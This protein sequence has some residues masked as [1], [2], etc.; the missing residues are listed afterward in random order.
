MRGR[1]AS[2]LR[3]I[4]RPCRHGTTWWPPTGQAHR[5]PTAEL[6][7]A[8]SCPIPSE[9]VAAERLLVHELDAAHEQLVGTEQMSRDHAGVLDVRELPSQQLCLEGLDAVGR[10]DVRTPGPGRLS[11]GPSCSAKDLPGGL[12]ARSLQAGRG[13]GPARRRS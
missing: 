1:P 9:T 2:T 7:G 8:N 5:L 4:A 10:R 6:D 3:D 13:A 11:L 12:P